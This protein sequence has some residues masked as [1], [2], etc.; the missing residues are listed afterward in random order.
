MGREG[1]DIVMSG[2]AY[3]ATVYTNHPKGTD[4]AYRM[5]VKAA[6][7]LSRHVL[8]V[9]SPVVH[10]HPLEAIGGLKKSHAEWL[11]FDLPMMYAASEL[12]VLDT[13]KVDTSAGVGVEIEA[14]RSQDK[15]IIFIAPSEL[16][17][18]IEELG[19]DRDMFCCHLT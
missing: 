1:I 18:T 2:F 9:Y 11:A 14:F 6:A 15:P 12:I 19:F 16:G 3:L 13:P 17:L 4:A 7:A 10:C 8:S 5:A